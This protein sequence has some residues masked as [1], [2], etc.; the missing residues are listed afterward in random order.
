MLSA[1]PDSLPH[2]SPIDSRTLAIIAIKITLVILAEILVVAFLLFYGAG[3]IRW[4]GGWVLLI[5]ATASLA[6]AIIALAIHDPGLLDAR[7]KLAPKGQPLADRLFV[8]IHSALMLAWAWVA[9]TDC[10]RHQWSHVPFDLRVAAAML[11][12]VATWAGYRTMRQNP[13][14]TT[15]V[16]LQEDRAHRVIDTGAYAVVRHPFYAV[17]I[18]YQFCASLVLGSWLSLALAGVIAMLVG[19]RIGMEERYLERE[20]VGYSAYK[21]TT[22]W[23]LVPGLW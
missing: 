9:G 17:A 5:L 3:T 6:P 22:P 7:T 19:L 15:C 20:L 23:R 14:L 21:Q 16:Y 1:G 18:A 4:A 13:Y 10:V 12:P 2:R 8:P 11:I